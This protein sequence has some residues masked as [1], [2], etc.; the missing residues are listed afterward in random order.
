LRQERL[1][2]EVDLMT[3][4]IKDCDDEVAKLK[5]LATTQILAFYRST[6][7]SRQPVFFFD[8]GIRLE[9]IKSYREALIQFDEYRMSLEAFMRG[10]QVGNA[11]KY[12][13]ELKK[14]G[15][16]SITYGVWPLGKSG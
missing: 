15:P 2:W 9:Q 13:R 14:A 7:S 8:E 4:R 1:G 6:L 10:I 5:P 12:R 16:K 11:T 3:K